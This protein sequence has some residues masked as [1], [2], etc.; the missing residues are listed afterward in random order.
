[1]HM[2]DVHISSL[3]PD[4]SP[5]TRRTQAGKAG[6]RHRLP[7]PEQSNVYVRNAQRCSPIPAGQQGHLVAEFGKGLGLSNRYGHWAA[8]S[9]VSAYE[10][11]YLQDAHRGPLLKSARRLSGETYERGRRWTCGSTKARRSTSRGIADWWDPPSGDTSGNKASPH[12][13]GPPRRRSTC[14]IER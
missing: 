9:A 4:I 2:H 7:S 8:V 3:P 6:A 13:S 14:A 11:Y 10:R 1:M 5:D 12:W